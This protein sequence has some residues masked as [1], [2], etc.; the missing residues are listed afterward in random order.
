MDVNNMKLTLTEGTARRSIT[1]HDM[2]LA[3]RKSET[4]PMIIPP[5]GIQ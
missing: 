1:T 4:I 5:A 2:A 3:L